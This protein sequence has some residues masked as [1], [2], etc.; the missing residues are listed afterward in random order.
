MIMDENKEN[1]NS[2]E[3]KKLDP[4]QA[5]NT[6]NN[7]YNKYVELEKAREEYKTERDRIQADKEKALA[8]IAAIKDVLMTYLNRSFDERAIMIK[9]NFE[10]IDTAIANN[11][12]EALAITVQ[13]VNTLVAQSPFKAL[14]DL[15]QVRRELLSNDK[16]E[17]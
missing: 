2:I 6:L 11:N 17:I 15:A 10:V 9:Q 13:S 5:L 7:L 12:M 14:V 8:Q 4:E 16:L 3:K 1:N